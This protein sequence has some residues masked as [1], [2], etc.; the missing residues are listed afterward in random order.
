MK[1]RIEFDN[2]GLLK[3]LYKNHK[4]PIK[5][6]N[7]YKSY[8]ERLEISYDSQYPNSRFYGRNGVIFFELNNNVYDGWYLWVHYKIW[9]YIETISR[10]EYEEIQDFVKS[11]MLHI[12][13]SDVTPVYADSQ[14]WWVK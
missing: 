3:L 5:L 8:T 10:F 6:V 1:K 14:S 13:P 12:V 7:F 2:H 11:Q 9:T 4:Y